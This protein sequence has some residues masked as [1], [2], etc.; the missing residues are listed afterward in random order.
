MAD[1]SAAETAGQRDTVADATLTAQPST[2]RRLVREPLLHFLL[3]GLALFVVYDNLRPAAENKSETNRIVLTPGDFEQ[4]AVTWLAQ[5]RAPPTPAQMQ[6]L[7]ELKIREEVLYRE[8]LALGLDKGD[9][10]VKRRLAQKME[11]LIEGG[12]I[13]SDPS[14][15][16]LRAWFQENGQRFLLPAR[17]SFRH[18]YFSPDR[19]GENSREAA[20]R[21]LE[22]LAGKPGD[23]KEAESLGDP[24]MDRDYYG[25]RS[26]ADLGKL[27][28]LNFAQAVASLKP[29]AWQGPV[30][31]GY[32]WHLIFVEASTPARVPSFEEIEPDIK[33]E[34]IDDQRTQ[35]KRKAYETMR[36]RYEVVLPEKSGN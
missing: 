13:D 34:W 33:A 17:V 2:L 3:I 6:S 24:F 12:S 1:R 18:L 28:G 31:S 29:G 26:A 8:A 7:V 14:A 30:E 20:A 16:T 23:W 32:G 11:F 15:D 9:T 27:F 25:D 4:L 5:G 22:Q 21:A 19:R 10:I 36:A 35:A